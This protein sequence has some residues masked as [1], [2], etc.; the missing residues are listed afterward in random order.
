[1]ASS[2]S[3]CALSEAYGIQTTM[4]DTD[5]A[6]AV[7]PVADERVHRDRRRRP[8]PMVSRY[9]FRG[10]RRAGRRA[11]EQN[12][13]YVDQPQRRVL[14][15]CLFVLLCSIADAYVTLGMVSAGSSEANP[16]MEA[17]LSLGSAPFVVLK[18]TLTF[19]G[20]AVL[21]LHQ[22][23][24]LGRAGLLIALGGYGILVLYHLAMQSLALWLD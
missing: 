10:R 5:T 3:S 9:L 17:V 19:F 15:T 22:N 24:P 21:C 8:T 16:L 23:W 11:S 12:H 18:T 7:R 4:S 1:M 20:A 6:L 14:A 13:Q 2:G